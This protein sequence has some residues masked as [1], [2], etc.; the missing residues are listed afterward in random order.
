MVGIAFIAC[1]SKAYMAMHTLQFSHRTPSRQAE[2]KGRRRHACIFKE[3]ADVGVSSH[4]RPQEGRLK[5][6]LARCVRLEDCV[7]VGII[8]QRRERLCTRIE[9]TPSSVPGSSHLRFPA[10]RSYEWDETVVREQCTREP[11]NG[12]S[13][14]SGLKTEVLLERM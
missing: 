3:H 11:T 5:V 14:R 2:S 8:L 6:R 1:A 4:R 9:V 7:Q 13:N 12:V 10:A